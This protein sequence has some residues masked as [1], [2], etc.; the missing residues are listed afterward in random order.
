MM[1]HPSLFLVWA[2]ALGL[3]VA[4]T[5]AAAQEHR[6]ALVI[7]NAD[8]RTAPLKNPVNDA[9]AMASTLRNLGFEV[10]TTEN[11][12][13][14]AMLQKL[15]EF[16]D[17]LRPESVAL[18]YYAG[19]GIQVKGQ[20][21]L[22]PADAVV[23]S[24]AEIDEESVNLAHLLERLDE[25]KNAM[26]IVILD[27]C[28]DNPFQRSFRSAS[29]GLAQVDAPTGTLIAYATAPGRTAADGDG[30]N[31]LYTEEIL[32]ALRVP[33]LKVEDV[34]KRVRANVVR[35]THGVQT[36]WDASS[37]V[38]DFYFTAAPAAP[39]PQVAEAT[40]STSPSA[41]TIAAALPSAARTAHVADGVW[42]LFMQCSGFVGWNH[43]LLGRRVTGGK[44]VGRSAANASP[45]RWDLAFELPGPDRLEVAGTLTD[46]QGKTGRYTA[47]AAL[48][49]GAF[50][51]RGAF[52]DYD[53]TFEARRVQ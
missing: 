5:T 53:C 30:T 16:R 8:Y 4:G 36:P 48:A 51:G 47:A 50:T 7:G 6:V 27:A 33:G 21:Y 34:L 15:R 11:A 38:G 22:I 3:T 1:R 19:H 18:F 10:L 39:A 26:N 37:L 43:T 46:A 32:R 31:G 52:D 28:R 9:R 17:R 24:E 12:G 14:K 2:L 49:G 42:S 45:E 44:M 13:R 23:R 29:R 41:A 35:R 20:N 25:A 40:G